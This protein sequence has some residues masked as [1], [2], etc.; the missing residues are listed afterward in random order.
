[1]FGRNN[2]YLFYCEIFVL[3]SSSFICEDTIGSRMFPAI[4]IS[5]VVACFYCNGEEASSLPDST[6]WCQNT[7]NRASVFRRYELADLQ[8]LC[9]A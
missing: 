5:S 4:S 2:N 8:N 6:K 9:C 1:M 7:E 3:D